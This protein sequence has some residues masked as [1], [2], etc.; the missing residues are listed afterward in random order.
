MPWNFSFDDIGNII[1]DQFGTPDFD[2]A[3]ELFYAVNALDAIDDQQGRAIAWWNSKWGARVGY[4]MKPIPSNCFFL[5]APDNTNN[6]GLFVMSAGDYLEKDSYDEEVERM[7]FVYMSGEEQLQG[8]KAA[9]YGA[10]IISGFYLGMIKSILRAMPVTRLITGWPDD[11]PGL[12]DLVKF[13]RTRRP[14]VKILP[15]SADL[16]IQSVIN[17]DL[18]I[19]PRKIPKTAV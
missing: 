18:F 15:N 16:G 6:R 5:G 2:C 1:S 17:M 3:P 10:P 14:D 13:V 7:I 11:L 12:K 19:K 4:E 9:K 8:T